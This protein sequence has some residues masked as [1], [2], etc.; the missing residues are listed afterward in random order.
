V[1]ASDLQ[2]VVPSGV[3]K[4][5]I[6]PI[7]PISTLCIITKPEICGLLTDWIESLDFM[8]CTSDLNPRD[9]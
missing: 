6:N 1:C 2:S 7:H 5:S 4:R 8:N 3:Y 9:G